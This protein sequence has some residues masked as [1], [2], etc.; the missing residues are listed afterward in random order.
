[1]PIFTKKARQRS[2]NTNIMVS[3]A[4]GVLAKHRSAQPLQ[5]RW[6]QLRAD[7]RQNTEA[8]THATNIVISAAGSSSAN[9]E[10]PRQYK[11]NGFSCSQFA[12]KTQKRS[13][14]TNIAISS[15]IDHGKTQKRSDI[16]N[17]AVSVVASSTKGCEMLRRNAWHPV[18]SK[19]NCVRCGYL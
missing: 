17:I 8:L 10:A 12:G 3:A 7:H 6:L 13:D 16:T 5:V 19:L 15:A 11:F 9:A 14:D 2:D 4:A 18:L 1:M